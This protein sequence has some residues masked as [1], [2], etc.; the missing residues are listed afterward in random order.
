M[1]G[2]CVELKERLERAERQINALKHV[3]RILQ[4]ECRDWKDLSLKFR[5][6]LEINLQKRD[7]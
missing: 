5:R 2:N 6:L 4:R 1:E 3:I 7:L